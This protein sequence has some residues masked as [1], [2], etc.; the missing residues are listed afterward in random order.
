MESYDRRWYIQILSV[1]DDPVSSR[2]ESDTWLERGKSFIQRNDKW[3]QMED[4]RNR[5]VM[6]SCYAV[7]ACSD[8][9][10][11]SSSTV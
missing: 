2:R 10:S 7:K 4:V 5:S 8:C 11:V 6:Y 3:I 1:P 9:R